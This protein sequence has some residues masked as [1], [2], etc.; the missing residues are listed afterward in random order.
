[1]IAYASRTGTR[2]NL[3]ALR[4]AGWRLFVSPVCPRTEGFRYALDNGAWPAFTAKKSLDIERFL[5]MLRKLGPEADFVISP[6]IVCGGAESL[7][8]SLQ[9]LDDCLRSCQRVLIAVQ[10]GM[11]ARDVERYL[12]NR[13]GVFVGGDTPWK[14]STMGEWASLA[15]SRG[16]WCHVGRVNSPTRIRLCKIAGADSFDGSKCSRFS[17]EIPSMQAALAQGVLFGGTP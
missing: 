7:A 8:L 3:D 4:E 1:M 14:L 15:R 13:V 10:N 17:I 11:V 12:D 16:A 6:D 5:R 9:W 2:R